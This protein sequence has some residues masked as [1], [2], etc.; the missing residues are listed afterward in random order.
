MGRKTIATPEKN[1]EKQEISII[2]VFDFIIRA[3]D[4]KIRAFD[5]KIRDSD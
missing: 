1:R 2:R 3:Y 5:Y 4:Y